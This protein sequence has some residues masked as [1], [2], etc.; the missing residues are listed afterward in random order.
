MADDY[1]M[2]DLGE[3]SIRAVEADSVVVG[4]SS[5]NRCEVTLALGFDGN[6]YMLECSP[7]RARQIAASLLNKADSADQASAAGL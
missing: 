2:E 4:I 3:L 6:Y 1:D 7:A 5:D